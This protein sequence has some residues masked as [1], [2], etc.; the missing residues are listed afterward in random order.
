MNFSK[1]KSETRAIMELDNPG[2]TMIES[3]IRSG[4]NEDEQPER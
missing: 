3:R 4:N 2:Y 1:T